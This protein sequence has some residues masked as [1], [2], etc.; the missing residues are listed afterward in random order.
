MMRENML[1]ILNT[2]QR[3]TIDD[4]LGYIIPAVTIIL[5]F[6]AIWQAF[7]RR[8]L[9]NFIRV[10]TMELYRDTGIMLGAAQECLGAIEDNNRQSATS[11]A[12]RTEGMAQ[13]LFQKSIKNIQHQFS[14]STKT[15]DSWIKKK[16]IDDHHRDDFLKYAKK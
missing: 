3:I 7:S 5:V 11:A 10:D 4:Y 13:T 14:Y 8:K 16:K 1:E 9:E 15:V 6:I 2:L 12:G